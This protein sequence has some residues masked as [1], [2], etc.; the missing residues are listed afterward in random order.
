MFLLNKYSLTYIGEQEKRCHHFNHTFR[1]DW[2][3]CQLSSSS[4]KHENTTARAQQ[5]GI[6]QSAVKSCKWW[7]P[8]TSE[9]FMKSPPHAFK[10]C[11]TTHRAVTDEWSE[12]PEGTSVTG[13]R[14]WHTTCFVQKETF[15]LKLIWERRER[16]QT[17]KW[18]ECR[19]SAVTVK[20]KV[21]HLLGAIAT[22]ALNQS[23][24]WWWIYTES[25]TMSSAELHKRN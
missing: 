13:A 25:S 9:A 5:N 24:I 15:K 21:V 16:Q 10:P 11:N 17:I 12:I 23:D 19:M 14:T 18:E 4:F 1:S 22:Q 3:V 6:C 20:Y 2:V 8:Q 7:T